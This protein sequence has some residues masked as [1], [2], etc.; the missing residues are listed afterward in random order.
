M[1]LC[2][3]ISCHNTDFV[4][5]DNV[6]EV[7]VGLIIATSFTS[8]V[9]TLVSE[10]LLPPISLIP[11]MEHKNLPEKFWILR[12]GP[13]AGVNSTHGYNTL[14]QARDDGAVTMAYG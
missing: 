9:N 7:A 3:Y 2:R 1:S 10:V 8:L 6:L 5:R 13:N 4:A 14:Q 11:G 12:K